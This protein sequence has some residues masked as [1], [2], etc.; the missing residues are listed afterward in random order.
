MPS[1]KKKNPHGHL[2]S[3]GAIRHRVKR[4]DSRKKPGKTAVADSFTNRSLHQKVKTAKGRKLASTLWLQRQI[5]DP[6]VQEAR[7]LGYR[8]RAAFK[9]IQIDDKFRLLKPGMNV[10]DLG[11]APGGWTQVALTRCKPEGKGQRAAQAQI[12]GIDLLE[13]DPFP[14]AK[15]IVGDI[16]DPQTAKALQDLLQGPADIVLSDMA[17]ATTGHPATDHLRIV[18]LCETALDFAEQ[19]L[20]PGG[21]FVAKVFQGGAEGAL[22][23]R[24]RQSFETVRHMKPPASRTDSS[25][26]YVIATGFRRQKQTCPPKEGAETG[27]LPTL[28]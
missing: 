26:Q 6:Y 21:H 25:E 14:G 27:F 16:E 28:K 10:V 4:E 2:T 22:L 20:R 1:G 7:R 11:A 13:I 9:L 15:L 12:V 8:S 23:T 5:N 24:L 17:P 3:G 19:V 18:A